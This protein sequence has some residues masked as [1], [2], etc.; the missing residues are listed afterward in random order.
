M[1]LDFGATYHHHVGRLLA[2]ADPRLTRPLEKEILAA[3][4]FDEHNREP[5]L[6]RQRLLDWDELGGCG[7]SWRRSARK[8]RRAE[9]LTQTRYH[10]AGD[11]VEAMARQGVQDTDRM[12][13]VLVQTIVEYQD[14]PLAQCSRLGSPGG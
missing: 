6:R 7:A 9:Y 8:A 1:E 11:V 10:E 12:M 2:E 3:P 14:N 5:F 13:S 4:G